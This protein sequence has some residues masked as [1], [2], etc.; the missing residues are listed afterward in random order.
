MNKFESPPLKKKILNITRPTNIKM[1]IKCKNIFLQDVYHKLVP[2]DFDGNNSDDLNNIIDKMIPFYHRNCKVINY[3]YMLNF[4]VEN[5]IGIRPPQDFYY[6][7]YKIR[8]HTYIPLHYNY[9]I[10]SSTLPNDMQKDV[11]DKLKY[12]NVHINQINNA[13]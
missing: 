13:N 7:P 2:F 1:K 11:F 5:D 9:Y 12:N 8:Y 6:D 4:D 10:K 3:Q